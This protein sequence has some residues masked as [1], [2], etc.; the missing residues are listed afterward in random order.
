MIRIQLPTRI[1]IRV[2][3]RSKKKPYQPVQLNPYRNWHFQYN[4]KLKQKYSEMMQP[5]LSTF[6]KLVPPI[7][8]SYTLR[9]K[10]R[11]KRD[12]GNMCYIVDKFFCDALV[13]QGLIP[14]D[15]Y[16]N[17]DDIRFNF[18]GLDK[19][20]PESYII[21]VTIYDRTDICK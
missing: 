17:I 3:K 16:F 10:D 2:G 4:N 11:H 15:D 9:A 8:L 14:D 12:L 21:E 6:D 19:S 7:R 18:A 20:V 5:I 13:K 1:P